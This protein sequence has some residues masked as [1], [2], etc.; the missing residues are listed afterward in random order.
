M[1]GWEQAG[2]SGSSA[3]HPAQAATGHGTEIPWVSQRCH[4][5]DAGGQDPIWEGA[6]E[7]SG[8]SDSRTALVLV[9]GN[10][11]GR[12]CAVQ[13]GIPKPHHSSAAR[14]DPHS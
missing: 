9:V 5:H 10:S 6:G 2:C 14:W 1:P 4:C 8:V 13:R 3:S 7:A 11:P 12:G